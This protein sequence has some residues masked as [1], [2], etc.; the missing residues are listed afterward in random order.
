M[1]R[2]A[3]TPRE[4]RYWDHANDGPVPEAYWEQRARHA[5]V[6]ERHQR[7]VDAIAAWIVAAIVAALIVSVIVTQLLGYGPIR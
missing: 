2:P 3:R 5:K 7:E 4:L 6:M 1:T